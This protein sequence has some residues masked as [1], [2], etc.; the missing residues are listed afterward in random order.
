MTTK[1]KNFSD[2]SKSAY[3]VLNGEA[4]IKINY[5]KLEDLW[6]PMVKTWFK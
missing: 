1:C 2:L 5:H 4:E 6:S 3:L